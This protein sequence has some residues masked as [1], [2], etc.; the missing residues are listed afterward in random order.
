VDVILLHL[1]KVF[2]RSID[3]DAKDTFIFFY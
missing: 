2:C 3:A 1:A